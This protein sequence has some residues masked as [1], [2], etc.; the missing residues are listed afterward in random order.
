M[1]NFS[2]TSW[3][4]Q[5]TFN[6]IIMRS[7]LY[8]TNTLSWIFIVL[9]HWKIN[10]R[11]EVLPNSDTLS[12]FLAKN[13]LLFLLNA[14]CLATNINFKV[15]TGART[16]DLTHLRRACQSLH[17]MCGFLRRACQSLLHMCGFLRRACQSLLHMC[18]FLRRACQSLHH[19]C[20]F[21]MC[22]F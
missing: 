5:I 9:T 4:E 22:V 13:S 16:N 15:P 2:I 1:S 8:K 6:E 14:V 17:H 12:W 20:G 10:P 3:R 11:V 7:A 18:G 19:M 21:L